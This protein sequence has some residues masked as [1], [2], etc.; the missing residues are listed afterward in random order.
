MVH[1]RAAVCS[2]RANIGQGFGACKGNGRG[3]ATWTLDARAARMAGFAGVR[4]QPC[5]A[6][7]VALRSASS[8]P[9]MSLAVAT[10]A[11]RFDASAGERPERRVS[12]HNAGF[13]ATAW[14]RNGRRSAL[15]ARVCGHRRSSGTTGGDGRQR[16]RS[17]DIC[18]GFAVWSGLSGVIEVSPHD[19]HALLTRPASESRRRVTRLSRCR[20]CRG[21]RNRAAPGRSRR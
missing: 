5:A 19:L 17:P 10:V 18:R 4:S 11:I 21:G 9:V 20:R 7:P 6:L 8:A 3:A 12:G 14:D 13:Q 15:R 16:R 1:R 2:L